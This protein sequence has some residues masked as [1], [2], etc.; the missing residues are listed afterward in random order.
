M[1]IVRNGPPE[2]SV[3]E[4]NLG[5]SRSVETLVTSLLGI[6]YGFLFCRDG[7]RCQHVASVT[8]QPEACGWGK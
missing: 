3:R 5:S 2:E 7:R 6:C 1:F 8:I 4:N